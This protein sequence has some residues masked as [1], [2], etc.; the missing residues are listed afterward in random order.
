MR[1]M[2]VD[3]RAD[4]GN[5]IYGE[6][7]DL[8]LGLVNSAYEGEEFLINS[9]QNLVS[10]STIY[11]LT[12]DVSSTGTCFV[13]DADGVN[14]DCQ[15]H[16][17][18]YS[19]S[20]G[21]NQYGI[22]VSEYQTDKGDYF[23]IKNCIIKDGNFASVNSNRNGI[24]LYYADEGIIENTTINSSSSGMTLSVSSNNLFTGNTIRSNT[25]IVA[26]MYG[27]SGNEFR[28]NVIS[29]DSGNAM[30]FYNL[31]NTI[32]INNTMNSRTN[33]ALWM[34]LSS[35]CSVINNT[36]TSDSSYGV[37]TEIDNS[38][39]ESNKIS[40]NSG[41][42]IFISGSNNM[43]EYNLVTSNLNEGI[44]IEGGINNTFISNKVTSLSNTGI[45]IQ[46]SNN[47]LINQTAIGGTRGIAIWGG[48][49][50]SIKDCN[51]ISGGD[52]DFYIGF[53]PG[54]NNNSVVNCSYDSE[55]VSGGSGEILRKWYLDYYVTGSSGIGATVNSYNLLSALEQSTITNSSG[56]TRQ[57]LTE[58]INTGSRTYRTPHTVNV[59][60]TGYNTNTMNYDLT[61]LKNV[62]ATITLT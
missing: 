15:G 19:T 61:A 56:R 26:Y 12:Q 51:S 46:S 25:E 21:S 34:R 1:N 42:G 54:A 24:N 13:F 17:I 45:R 43:L 3:A 38:I 49:G 41:R 28:N 4:A 58:Y 53:Y 20:G 44:Y 48:A 11:K 33:S 30:F 62:F 52:Y 32:L 6:R 50:N 27:G 36:F 14:L 29:S 16:T 9:C 18:T 47:I 35:N 22:Q 31:N 23:N 60:K 10:P 37:Q 55:Y 59:I 40:S 2:L 5:T 7:I 39:F 57:E 8:L